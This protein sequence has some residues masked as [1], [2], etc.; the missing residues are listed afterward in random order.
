MATYGVTKC[1]I[2]RTEAVLNTNR[3]HISV[4]CN[5]GLSNPKTYY[6]ITNPIP[7]PYHDLISIQKAIGLFSSTQ[8]KNNM[9]WT[10][11]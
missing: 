9:E 7:P 4:E 2:C 11:F 1:S 5:M 10:L 8:S 3:N 6:L